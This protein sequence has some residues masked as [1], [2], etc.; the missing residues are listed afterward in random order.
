MND[1][2][3]H[4]LATWEKIE[5]LH[6]TRRDY[7]SASQIYIGGVP[8]TWNMTPCPVCLTLISE[9]SKNQPHPIDV[10]NSDSAIFIIEH[11]HVV[12]TTEGESG[13]SKIERITHMA[14]TG[15]W[16]LLYAVEN[17]LS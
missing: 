17:M 6:G 11:I 16:R 8:D 4:V 10:Q 13:N 7:A 2:R 5:V 12:Q 15:S 1:V 14:N 9:F 3:E